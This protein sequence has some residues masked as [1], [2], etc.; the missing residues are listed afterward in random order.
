MRSELRG[1]AGIGLAFAGDGMRDVFLHLVRQRRAP[2]HARAHAHVG[3]TAARSQGALARLAE[4][5]LLRHVTA[6][7]CVGSGA[8]GAAD[9]A[10]GHAALPWPLRR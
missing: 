3:L 8:I 4:L 1:G 7:S 6:I 9:A 10:R 5:D 2:A